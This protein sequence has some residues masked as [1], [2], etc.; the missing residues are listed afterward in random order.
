MATLRY[1]V[2]SWQDVGARSWMLEDAQLL[3]RGGV[4]SEDTHVNSEVSGS[5]PTFRALQR[6]DCVTRTDFKFVCS[7]KSFDKPCTCLCAIQL[8]RWP[9][10]GLEVNDFNFGKVVSRKCLIRILHGSESSVLPTLTQRT[11]ANC[12]S[13]PRP[14]IRDGYC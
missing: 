5:P 9:H 3:A 4:C 14:L 13:E 2:F 10:F 7:H 8:A 1:I 6:C 12:L 11:A